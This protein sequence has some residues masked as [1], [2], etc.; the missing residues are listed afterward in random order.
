MNRT[1][2]AKRSEYGKVI[3]AHILVRSINKIL[4]PNTDRP[5][6]FLQFLNPEA[7]PDS[8]H[9]HCRI[10]SEGAAESHVS[11]RY[12]R[13]E[14]VQSSATSV[15]RL[16]TVI[17]ILRYVVYVNVDRKVEHSKCGSVNCCRIF[18]VL[19]AAVDMQLRRNAMRIR[20]IWQLHKLP[21]RDRRQKC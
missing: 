13:M 4:L 9:I 18:V 7:E 10:G 1:T 5:G 11:Q 19:A 3:D 21:H 8:V 2:Y 12:A 16:M 17:I 15:C 6:M 14:P 20:R